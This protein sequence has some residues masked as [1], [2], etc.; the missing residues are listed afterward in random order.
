MSKGWF[1]TTLTW[2]LPQR[3]PCLGWCKAC[4]LYFHGL[5]CT[6]NLGVSYH[7]SVFFHMFPS[8]SCQVLQ[9]FSQLRCPFLLP[10]QA[11]QRFR[12]HPVSVWVCIRPSAV[13]LLL[14]LTP[15]AS[16]TNRAPGEAGCNH[17][18]S[19]SPEQICLALGRGKK[20]FSKEK[21]P[22]DFIS[23]GWSQIVCIVLSLQHMQ[24]EFKTILGTQIMQHPGVSVLLL[25][26]R[27]SL[28]G[29]VWV[30]STA[31][32]SASVLILLSGLCFSSSFGCCDI[33][34]QCEI[35]AVRQ[36]F[37]QNDG[38]RRMEP[39]YVCTSQAE[40]SL[41]FG[42]LLELLNLREQ[43]YTGVRVKAWWCECILYIPKERPFLCLWRTLKIKKLI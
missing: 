34:Q 1:I 5:R 23:G 37:S 19:S 25:L 26:N 28:L 33:K 22:L 14:P 13:V 8:F 31:V 7:N 27:T 20:D 38:L 12:A 6:E 36:F 10:S 39:E 2:I 30:L 40:D 42:E 15:R 9:F 41:H 35:K 21:H 4:R 3:C 16:G 32:C 43:P 18:D 11:R 24:Q 17:S 29:L